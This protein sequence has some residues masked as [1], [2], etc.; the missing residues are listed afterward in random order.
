MYKVVTEAQRILRGKQ[1]DDFDPALVL[2]YLFYL[3][4]KGIEKREKRKRAR[5]RRV[6]LPS[7][8][9]FNVANPGERKLVRDASPV[10]QS[11][12]RGVSQGPNDRVL[13]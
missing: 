5:K 12:T 8:S 13:L 4:E 9:S 6:S 10:H 11:R 2:S 1:V 3:R 7:S